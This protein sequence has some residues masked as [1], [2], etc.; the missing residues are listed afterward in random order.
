MDRPAVAGVFVALGGIN[1][2][3]Q[4]LYS[5]NG[6]RA[7]GR[8]IEAH[9]AQGLELRARQPLRE[10]PTLGQSMTDGERERGQLGATREIPVWADGIRHLVVVVREVRVDLLLA[11]TWRLVN[12]I[13][14][15][16]QIQARHT[17]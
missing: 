10:R 3:A 6:V 2:W 5:M 9:A 4:M 12:E 15:T 14:A 11:I 13:H 17:G 7:S 1:L 8:V 16:A